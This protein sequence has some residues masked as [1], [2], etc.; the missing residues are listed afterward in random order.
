MY[1]LFI[2]TNLQI[3][4]PVGIMPSRRP[5]RWGEGR[6][7]SAQC[8]FWMG[9]EFMPRAFISPV[10]ACTGGPCGQH[11]LGSQPWTVASIPANP[12]AQMKGNSTLRRLSVSCQVPFLFLRS[13]VLFKNV[14]S[15]CVRKPVVRSTLFL[16]LFWSR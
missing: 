15:H 13:Q 3:V 5:Q 11:A 16:S 6:L 12:G 10:P 4:S 2:L 7:S 1:S 8:S 9:L 14:A